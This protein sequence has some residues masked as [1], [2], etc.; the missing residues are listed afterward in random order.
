MAMS[1]FTE[2]HIAPNTPELFGGFVI[3]REG[4]R[5][6]NDGVARCRRGRLNRRSEIMLQS[7]GTWRGQTAV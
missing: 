4:F 3:H 2:R 5:A 1:G 6:P 7:V